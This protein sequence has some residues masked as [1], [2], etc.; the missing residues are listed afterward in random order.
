MSTTRR[1]NGHTSILV[2]RAA[3]YLRYPR[4]AWKYGNGRAK[5]LIL[6]TY[7]LVGSYVL[8]LALLSVG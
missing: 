7:A 5:V 1:S 6:A 8:T 4:I 3:A 2:G